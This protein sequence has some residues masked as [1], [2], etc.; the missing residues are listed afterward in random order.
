MGGSISGTDIKIM[1]VSGLS[2]SNA[3]MPSIVPAPF[4]AYRL[5]LGEQPLNVVAKRDDAPLE[6]G[7]GCSLGRCLNGQIA[8]R[9]LKRINQN[10]VW[11]RHSRS[12]TN[13]DYRTPSGRSGRER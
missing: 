12:G 5:R 1:I 13:P 4:V 7:D 9:T 11:T 2:I 10:D 8:Q 3:T 6:Q